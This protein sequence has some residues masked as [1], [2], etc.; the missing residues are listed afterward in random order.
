MTAPEE[1]LAFSRTRDM[2]QQDTIRRLFTLADFTE[3]DLKEALTMLKAQY[4]LQEGTPP[5]KR[6]QLLTLLRQ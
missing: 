6:H 2:W 4:G 1:I 5:V 3:T